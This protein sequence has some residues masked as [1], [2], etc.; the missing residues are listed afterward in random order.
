M[1][2]QLVLLRRKGEIIIVNYFDSMLSNDKDV[3]LTIK[4]SV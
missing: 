1:R 4:E 2:S 3:D